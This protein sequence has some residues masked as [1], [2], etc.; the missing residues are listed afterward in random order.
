MTIIAL[1]HGREIKRYVA[2][3]CLQLAV[4]TPPRFYHGGNLHQLVGVGETV[5]GHFHFHFAHFHERVLV[6]TTQHFIRLQIIRIF[7]TNAH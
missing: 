2:S 5:P 1:L 6:Y 7:K 4:N 3:F